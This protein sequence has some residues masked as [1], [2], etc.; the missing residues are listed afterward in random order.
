MFD[1]LKRLGRRATGG[2][3]SRQDGCEA[4]TPEE[5]LAI[6][7]RATAEGD[8]VHAAF[9]V[10]CAVAADPSRP[11]YVG[12]LDR[13]LDLAPDPLAVAPLAEN[14]YFGT[15]AVRAY[16][17]ARLN[18]TDEA[19]DLL[20]QTVRAKPDAGYLPWAVRWLDE[21]RA[22]G[23]PVNVTETVAPFFGACITMLDGGAEDVPAEGVARLRRD[24]PEVARTARELAPND[25][26]LGMACVA[27][28]RRIGHLPEAARIAREIHD[29]S[30]SYHGA[31]ALASVL[32][33]TGD[34]EGAIQAYL[35]ALEHDPTD[36]AARLDAGDLSYQIGKLEDAEFYYGEVLAREAYHAWALPSLYAVRHLKTG[37]D[38]WEERLRQYAEAHPENGR[39]KELL[40]RGF[41]YFGEYLPDPQD[42]SV[43]LA[44]QFYQKWRDGEGP[45]VA[46]GNTIRV[47][48]SSLEAPSV[49]LALRRTIAEM[50][51][52]TVSVSFG[53]IQ[54]PDPRQPRAP[55]D[56]TLWAYD[57]NEAHPNVP[58]P[59]THVAEAV[60]RVARM[61]YSRESWWYA[62]RKAATEAGGADAIPALAATMVHP[63]ARPDDIPWWSWLY[64]VQI[65][66]AFAIARTE[67][68]WAASQRRR[69]LLSLANG[70]MDW[71]VDAAVVALSVIAQEDE[72]A[73]PEVARLFRDLRQ[74]APRPGH[75]CYEFPLLLAVLQMPG[76]TP[77]ERAEIQKRLREM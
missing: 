45:P 42:A 62:A 16:A 55:V 47:T 68:G 58:P 6:A 2:K 40:Q 54:T 65:A 76:L 20:F 53:Q 64:R 74:R 8:L 25:P 71:A 22:A 15:V 43:N 37:E 30:P 48:V 36:L 10:G 28:L 60:A 77:R 46:A 50:G 41:P 1:F 63:P 39:A 44:A 57:D 5:D 24:L 35:E 17:L 49:L 69:A 61:P 66:A 31:I 29:G 9:H 3:A 75:V 23:R 56:F 7:E 32:R 52:A 38:T 13:L 26:V 33:Q 72:S 11:E 19:L 67:E 70:P 59:P 18:R 12:A 73:A 27:V 51:E 34:M 21:A 4:K 14:N